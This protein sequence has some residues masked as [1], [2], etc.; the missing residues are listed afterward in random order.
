M[1]NRWLL[2]IGA[3]AL[4]LVT[5]FGLYSCTNSNCVDRGGHTE[6]VWGNKVGWTCVGAQR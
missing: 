5:N 6:I 1:K 2:L 3:L 4:A